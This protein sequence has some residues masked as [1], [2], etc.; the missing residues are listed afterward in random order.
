MLSQPRGPAGYEVGRDEEADPTHY[1][2]HRARDVVVKEKLKTSP[3]HFQ[4]GRK[5]GRVSQEIAY[6]NICK[7]VSAT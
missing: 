2:E 4:S 6:L 7:C 3:F 5:G 1:H